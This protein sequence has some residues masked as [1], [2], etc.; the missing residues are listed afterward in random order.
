MTTGNNSLL[1][2]LRISCRVTKI[3]HI[4]T[5]KH[6]PQSNS[7]ER[8]NR[9]LLAAI[10]SYLDTDQ[11]NWD[12]H[13][14]EVSCAIRTAVHDSIGRS[15]FM[16]L[17]GRN[18]MTHASEYAIL[19]ELKCLGDVD[20]NVV[21][22]EVHLDIIRDDI[23]KHL[24]ISSSNRAHNYNLRARK[25]TF[26]KGDLVFVRNFVQSDASKRFSAKLAPKF[27]KARIKCP[28]GE[29]AYRCEN[30]NGTDIGVFHLKDIHT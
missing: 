21:D 4:R 13:L 19:R 15:P 30:L 29:V 23:I 16:A 1:I 12:C 24:Q 18:I 9:T 22:P 7:S 10:R 27:V 20:V 6:S 17:F 5:P 11:R 2:D 3:L 14:D 8:V 25:R 28:V 26:S